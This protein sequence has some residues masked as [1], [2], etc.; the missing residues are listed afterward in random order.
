MSTSDCMIHNEFPFKVPYVSQYSLTW[1]CLFPVNKLPWNIWKSPSSKSTFQKVW[2]EVL[3]IS[4][5]CHL[6]I[7]TPPW[8]V[9]ALFYPSFKH[10]KGPTK[11]HFKQ[12]AETGCK[13]RGKDAIVFFWWWLLCKVIPQESG[14]DDK[15]Q[16]VGI[17][18]DPEGFYLAGEFLTAQ[19]QQ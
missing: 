6:L 7:Y 9:T 4:S 18:W 17:I 14:W 3:E 15:D 16:K 11:H 1:P 19:F 8:L 5:W 10:V 12:E 2:A 13:Q